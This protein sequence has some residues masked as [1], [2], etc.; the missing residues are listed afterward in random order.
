MTN[1]T[2][3]IILFVVILN[4]IL[5][6]GFYPRE[7]VEQ[8]VEVDITIEDVEVEVE[9][10]TATVTAY[11]STEAQTDSTPFITASGSHVSNGTLACPKRYNFGT[12]VQINGH[13]YVCEDRMSP[14]YGD[15]F[16]IWMETYDEAMEWGIQD[17]LVTVIIK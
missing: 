16:D 11:N 6:W 4:T 14:K 1:P 2:Q 8:S 10:F 5:L 9:E 15:R 3:N 7:E 13:M 17:V 12:Q